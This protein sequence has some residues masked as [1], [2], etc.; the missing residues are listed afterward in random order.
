M[1]VLVRGYT[2]CIGQPFEKEFVLCN[3]MVSVLVNLITFVKEHDVMGQL[4]DG[5]PPCGTLNIT[6]FKV[7]SM[8]FIPFSVYTFIGPVNMVFHEPCIDSYQKSSSIFSPMLS[9]SKLST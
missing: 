7:W 4:L 3:R 9:L 6:V 1:I 8:Q 2:I 5:I